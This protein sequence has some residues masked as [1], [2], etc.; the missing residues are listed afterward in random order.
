MSNTTH[1]GLR[2]PLRRRGL[3]TRSMLITSALASLAQAAPS[4]R[5]AL[6][7]PIPSWLAGSNVGLTQPNDLSDA[8]Q[9]NIDTNVF[10]GLKTFANH[11]RAGQIVV[12]N[13]P[14]TATSNNTEYILQSDLVSTGAGIIVK[15]SLKDWTVNLNGHTLTFGTA[16][17]VKNQTDCFGI[18][19]G[20]GSG[21]QIVNGRIVYGGGPGAN[22]NKGNYGEGYN[23][24]H[25]HWGGPAY[26]GGLYI[27]GSA[28]QSSL[29]S[30]FWMYRCRIEHNTFDDQSITIT[31]RHLPPRQIFC[32]GGSVVRW[33]RVLHARQ[34]GFG[35]GAGSLVECN[36]IYV[37]GQDTNAQCI[38]GGG[39]NTTVRCNNLYGTG[40]MPTGIGLGGDSP[41]SNWQIYSNWFEGM[42]TRQA[43]ETSGS[44]DD[45]QNHAV[46]IS[47]RWGLHTGNSIH[48][49]TLICYAKSQSVVGSAG[50]WDATGKAMFYEN[51]K[52]SENNVFASNVFAAVS[53]DG[54]A[55]TMHDHYTP[56][57]SKGAL[58]AV[59]VGPSGKTAGGVTFAGN[60][61][62]SDICPLSLPDAYVG[63]LGPNAVGQRL[64][65]TGNSIERLGAAP[66]FALISYGSGGGAPCVVDFIG[67]TYVNVA[68]DTAWDIAPGNAGSTNIAYRY[69]YWLTITCKAGGV[70]AAGATVT[71]T[72]A[73]GFRLDTQ[74]T[75]AG[76]TCQV[77]GMTK[78]HNATTDVVLTPL[79]IAAVSGT[80]S[81]S[82]TVTPTAATAYT[83][84]LSGT[85]GQGQRSAN[86]AP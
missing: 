22:D 73:T 47:M 72:D 76:G 30:G 5:P 58:T 74:T 14:F 28:N 17:P 55:R 24:I 56:N 40:A 44:L 62:I 53:L 20:N 23:P 75:D 51:G 6:F 2:P 50:T 12:T 7:G 10:A 84:N 45:Y 26:I 48:D 78:R 35:V 69:G 80:F 79:T 61:I 59:A 33:N 1:P 25:F 9:K 38:G 68:E 15:G 85:T 43:L 64:L 67:N 36:E 27:I 11:G 16:T 19:S 63:V 32:N 31:E 86:T 52:G 57:P 41:T 4:L 34:Y 42:Y 66:G 71:V 70:P 77:R 29:I 83:I 82:M 65:F 8:G 3:F 81:G 37:D 60:R 49:N 21:G 39:S 13:L 18:G 54:V 46:G